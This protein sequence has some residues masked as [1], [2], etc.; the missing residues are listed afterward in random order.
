MERHVGWEEELEHLSE[1]YSH[2]SYFSE[3][4]NEVFEVFPY[5]WGDCDCGYQEKEDEWSDENPHSPE[6]L[7]A[8]QA[9]TKFPECV[10]GNDKKWFAW[11]KILC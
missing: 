4:E 2:D 8:L 9:A 6:C 1:A 11:I 5:Y 10:C 7:K 3:F